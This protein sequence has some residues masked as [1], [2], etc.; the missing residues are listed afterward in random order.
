MEQHLKLKY[1]K[2]DSTCVFRRF[3]TKGAARRIKKQPL[4]TGF[5]RG[6]IKLLADPAVPLITRTHP[7]RTTLCKAFATLWGSICTGGRQRR[8]IW[9][10]GGSVC[11]HSSCPFKGLEKCTPMMV[12]IIVSRFITISRR[13]IRRNRSFQYEDPQVPQ[14][15][16]GEGREGNAFVSQCLPSTASPMHA[17]TSQYCLTALA[18]CK[19]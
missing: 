6:A 14:V 2:F 16:Y 17:K 12:V 7:P 4:K 13:H 8:G 19:C 9:G 15:T 11:K 10:W 3:Y 18:F 5:L 1:K